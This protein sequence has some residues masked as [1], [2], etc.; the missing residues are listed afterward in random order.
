MKRTL[1]A[2]AFN[3][4]ANHPEVRPWLGFGS[5]E[6]DLTAIVE[7]TSNV[8]FLTPEEDGGYILH[9]LHPGLYEAHTLALPSARGR[10]MLET[11][12]DG[13]ATMFMATDAIE[14]V[15]R[16]P[17]GNEKA[18]KWADVAG[19]REVFRREHAFMLMDETVGVSFRSL[20][21]GDWVLRD[22]R[23]LELGRLFHEKLSTH[24]G[25]I[26]H[27][28]D[29]VHDAWV[30]ATMGGCIEGN[31]SKAIGLFNRWAAFSG[32][33]QAT[34]LSL[35]PPMIHTGDATVQLV[36]GRLDVL[37]LGPLPS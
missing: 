31:V 4:I 21:Y 10:P 19:F 2:Q 22:K 33:H 8:C 11:M 17:D 12:R 28:D 20:H 25:H 35:N 26:P 36:S 29:P 37:K 15:T 34:I 18:A 24:S 5:G 7:D 3:V 27:A 30:G 9:K 23:H 32:Y 6:L 16:V 13:F 1:S 14:I